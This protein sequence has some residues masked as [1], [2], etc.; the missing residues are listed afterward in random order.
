MFTDISIERLIDEK[1]NM[2][3]I[4]VRS[5]SEY[6]DF[7]IPGSLNIPIFSD[8]ERAEV[9]TIYKQVGPEAAEERGLEIFSAKLPDFIKAFKQ[10][11]GDKTVFC[12]RG[13]MRSRTAATVLDLMKI[14]VHRL[15]GGIRSYRNWVVGQLDAL[16]LI[17][18]AYIL[19]GNTGTGKTIILRKL[20]QE[21]YPVLDFERMANHRGSIFGQIGLEPHNQKTFDA[22]LVEKLHIIQD[23]P[24]VFFEGESKRIG[25]VLLPEPFYNVKE[26]GTQIFIEMPMEER[27]KNILDDYRPWEFKEECM[28]AFRRIKS[29]IH[30]PIATEIQNALQNE[31]FS[32]AVRLLL[33]YYYDPRYLYSTAQYFKGTKITIS[34]Q[35]VEEAIEE[36]K[37]LV[38]HKKKLTS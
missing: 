32:L 25:R 16:D 19:N 8:A 7:T 4:D 11:E 1:K 38:V 24:Y 5:P 18:K 28:E 35:N 27:V 2:T 20:E 14:P 21:G 13:G 17:P 33:E 29:R 15:D 30:T 12:W 6:K 31:E 10:I 37:K 36:I 34:V 26:N 23:F 3:L 22:L 9:G